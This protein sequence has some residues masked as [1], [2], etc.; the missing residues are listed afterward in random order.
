MANTSD[1]GVF[2]FSRGGG[3]RIRRSRRTIFLIIYAVAIAALVTVVNLNFF[4]WAI[5][6]EAGT[7]QQ[8]ALL[9]A[10]WLGHH[11]KYQDSLLSSNASQ[12]DYSVHLLHSNLKKLKSEYDALQK[13][14]SAMEQDISSL[15][16]QSPVHTTNDN[17]T[18]VIATPE[19]PILMFLH[20]GKNGG[21]SF[22]HVAKKIAKDLQFSIYIGNKHYDWSRVEKI[23]REQALYQNGN[24][25]DVTGSK[26]DTVQVVT[27]L[28]DP[29]ARA[30]S[31]YWF[32]RKMSWT[33]GMTIREQT[34]S[35]YLFSPNN[36]QNL[37]ATR[38]IW[39]DGQAAVSWLSGTHI[40]SWVG[41]TK[42]EVPAREE[43]A[44]NAEAMCHLAADRLE[45]TR[46]FGILEDLNRSLELLQHEFGLPRR[47]VMGR[48]NKNIKKP[49]NFKPSELEQAALASLMPQDIWLY[50][51]SRRLFQARWDHYKNGTYV[52]PERPPLPE[53]WSCVST[54]VTLHCNSGP[55]VAVL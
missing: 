37:L 5:L 48:S 27:I 54:R 3:S 21:T 13:R 22:D 46:W 49:L 20:I 25:R 50:E 11:T 36:T 19:H 45:Q 18:S 12:S 15:R 7:Q 2:S 35:Q 23:Q 29:V 41:V 53:E 52:A 34:L 8:E 38:D 17:T 28:R 39:Q 10:S 6:N 42:A 16:I 40:A 33:K 14:V 4:S 47:P 32:Y 43:R 26:N 24:L 31:H 44:K 1:G 51:Y 55:L 30:I 9:R